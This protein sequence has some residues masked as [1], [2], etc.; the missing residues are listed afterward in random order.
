MEPCLNAAKAFLGARVPG[1]RRAHHRACRSARR[2]G[3]M[4]TEE[5]DRIMR[6]LEHASADLSWAWHNCD[7]RKLQRLIAAADTAISEAR[8]HAKGLK[9]AAAPG[10][11]ER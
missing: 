9:P 8:S 11:G 4:S 1:V 3:G 6:Y 5:H 7:D 2:G 10:E